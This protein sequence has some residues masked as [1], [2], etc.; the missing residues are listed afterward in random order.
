MV[1]FEQG[2][3]VQVVSLQVV[4]VQEQGWVQGSYQFGWQGYVVVEFVGC[5]CGF[6]LLFYC[7]IEVGDVDGQVVFVGDVLG[8]VEWEI[9]G[10][11]QV[12]GVN[13]WDYVIVG[14]VCYVF[15]DFYV[16]VE[17]FGEMFFFGLQC[18]GDGVYCCWQFWIGFVYLFDQGWYQFVEE[19]LLYVQY[20]VVVQGVVDDMVQYVVMVFV[21]GQYVVDDQE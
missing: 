21:G 17:G 8:Q 14:F 11:V 13:V 9:I 5:L 18:M 12:E 19:W 1:V 4:V 7:G 16:G 3:Y 10:V 20:L 2:Q 6:V 15:E